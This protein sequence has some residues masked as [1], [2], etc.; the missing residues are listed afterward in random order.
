MEDG[1]ACELVVFVE[2][3]RWRP[4]GSGRG[5]GSTRRP[6]LGFTIIFASFSLLV[7]PMDGYG[8]GDVVRVWMFTVMAPV[9]GS[10]GDG[11]G[12][13]GGVGV[14]IKMMRGWSDGV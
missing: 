6:R 7:C 3:T 8:G 12:A 9:V 13:S 14:V 2:E 4:G 11:G 5:K 10:G 1:V